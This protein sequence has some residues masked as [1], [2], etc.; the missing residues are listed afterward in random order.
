MTERAA[1]ARTAEGPEE[2][3]VLLAHDRGEVLIELARNPA[4]SPRTL[5]TIVAMR[6]FDAADLH[7]HLYHL[8]AV[9][10]VA[11]DPRCP[12]SV[13]HGLSGTFADRVVVNPACPPGLL[14]QYCEENW[15]RKV[16]VSAAQHPAT[17]TDSLLTV[18][19]AGGPA[20]AAAAHNIAGRDHASIRS[21]MLLTEASGRR[22]IARVVPDAEQQRLAED[23]DPRIR[24]AVAMTTTDAVLLTRL[25]HD[26]HGRVRRGASNRLLAA[27]G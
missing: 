26:P 16:N 18:I 14:A 24:Y 1:I 22:A 11:R 9:R 13:L 25:S 10:L 27:F 5:A 2:L 21:A 20:G 4:S 8:E 17:P 7:D 23:D 19:A 3:L 15:G 12:P 6:S